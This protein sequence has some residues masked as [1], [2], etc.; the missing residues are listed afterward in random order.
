MG[1]VLLVLLP[2]PCLCHISKVGWGRRWSIAL[3]RALLAL[4]GSPWSHWL[5][6]IFYLICLQP[7]NQSLGTAFWPLQS[8][9]QPEP[10]LQVEIAPRCSCSLEEDPLSSRLSSSSE[11]P[12]MGTG[13]WI[14]LDPLQSQCTLQSTEQLPQLS[15]AIR[16]QFSTNSFVITEC[17]QKTLGPVSRH[18]HRLRPIIVLYRVN[19]WRSKNI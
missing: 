10:S 18:M 15:K 17:S 3:M 5:I 7:A 9:S 19:L 12:D 6:I 16:G 1:Y 13:N 8:L 2:F 4:V 14:W 11:L